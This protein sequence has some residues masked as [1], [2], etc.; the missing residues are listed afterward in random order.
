MEIWKKIKNYENYEVS[1]FG[2]VKRTK[3]FQCESDRLLKKINNGND[4][5][6]VNLSK[7]SIKKRF[8][9]HRLV[10][11][12]FLETNKEKTEVNHIDGDKKNNNLCNLEWVTRS[13]NQNHRYNVLK[14]KGSN[15]GKTGELN[16]KSK[17]VAKMDLFNNVIKEY[18]AVMEAM[19]IT[20]INESCIRACIYGKQKT[21]GGFK[22]KYI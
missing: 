3:G 11:F 6:F 10:A 16:W 2:N 21:A 7:N 15:T 20:G 8:Y 4:Y 9:V 17:K 12:T 14:H 18:P 13:E 19:R 1:N 5:L 22:W